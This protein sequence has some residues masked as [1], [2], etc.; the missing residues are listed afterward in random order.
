[1]SRRGEIIGLQ[2]LRGFCA[3][4]VV[5]AHIS[6][7]AAYPKYFGRDFFV[8]TLSDGIY[9]VD[10]FFV[11]SGFIITIVTLDPSLRPKLSVGSF[12]WKRFAR[13]VPLMW[14]AIAMHLMLRAAASS[15]DLSLL[16]Y[17]RAAV[18]WPSG[19]LEPMVMWT[20]R[21]ELVFYI[22][23]AVFML[24]LP[25][26]R[27]VLL[28]WMAAPI[29]SDVL[30]GT[31]AAQAPSDT[32]IGLLV[33]G[34]NL[35]FGA[36][37]L[38]G[39]LYLKRPAVPLMASWVHPILMLGVSTV[40]L[41]AGARLLPFPWRSLPIAAYMAVSAAILISLAVRLRCPDDRLGNLG[42]L[43]GNAS[44]SI[45]LFHL[46][47]GSML[48]AIWAK[49]APTTP[50]GVAVPAIIVLTLA[51]GVA[52]HRFVERPLVA[53][54]QRGTRDQRRPANAILSG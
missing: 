44:Y 15:A 48:C 17:A 22:L 37:M 26:W 52:V 9:G 41:I 31:V 8:D 10:I 3:L 2:Y 20:L 35:E 34:V 6:S 14:V 7:M 47:A 24:A 27:W 36:G 53:L 49:L 43:L 25:R 33:N 40:A 39:I 5:C 13:I 21:H 16:S 42:E 46:H 32:P 54:V 51:I 50:V 11:I 45:Y 38:V 4:A 19:H 18:L 30:A 23:F 28:L 29:V 1:M 12:F